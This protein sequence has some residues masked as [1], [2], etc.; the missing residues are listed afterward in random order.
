MG[1]RITTAERK[2]ALYDSVTG[3]AFGPVFDS[4]EEA[5]SFLN[6][7]DLQGYGD[8]R[9]LTAATLD[10]EYA[11]WSAPRVADTGF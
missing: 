1:V 2:V 6:W 11:A 10:E 7:L 4:E 3:K 8:A 5:D 9:S